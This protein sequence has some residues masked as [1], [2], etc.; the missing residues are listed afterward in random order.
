[1]KYDAHSPVLLEEVLHGLNIRPDGRYI[2]ATFGRGGHAA[3][4]L[5]QLAGDGRLMVIDQ[6]PQAIETATTGVFD[7]PRVI[8]EHRSF[9]ELEDAVKAKDWQSSV[10]GILLDL[11]VSSPQLDDPNRGF[12]YMN[13]G[14]LD[15]RMNPTVG[16]SA[17]D[18]VNSAD[19]K[20]IAR[21]LWEYGEE[22]FSR[23]IARAI[24]Q[25]REKQPFT[26]TLQLAEVVSDAQFKKDKFK[27]PATRSF[28]AIRLHV[29]RELDVLEKV[30]EQAMRV[31]AVGGRLCV[32]SFHSLEDR[33]VKRFMRAAAK[34][35]EYP[36]DFPVQEKDLNRRAK[37]ISKGVTAS[38]EELK[39][40]RRA[41]SARLRIMEKL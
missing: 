3:A 16:E 25:H 39:N 31:L 4:I 6:D 27:H 14:P 37:V 8:V 38:S 29:N 22:R 7:D 1:M 13:D 30:L 9:A 15:M 20:E 19:E 18:W 5:Q 21:V 33:I 35:D 23:R 32:I 17:A 40:N 26:R 11:G 36:A 28:Q 10:D 34:G 2:D 24:V 41:R 12:S